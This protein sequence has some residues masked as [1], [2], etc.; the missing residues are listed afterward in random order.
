MSSSEQS[1][2]HRDISPIADIQERLAQ[3]SNLVAEIRDDLPE[4]HAEAMSRI[5]RGIGDLASRIAVFGHEEL[6]TAQ[7]SA[8]SVAGEDADADDPWDASRPK[9]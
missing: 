2:T 4:Q 6:P 7:I 3:F 1:K 5:E 9:P 8:P